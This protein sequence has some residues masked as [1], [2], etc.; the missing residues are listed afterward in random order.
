MNL[1]I[2]LRS[3]TRT[4]VIPGILIDLI[5]LLHKVKVHYVFKNNTEHSP[6]TVN[7]QLPTEFLGLF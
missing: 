4:S 2:C 1:E 6:G 7:L 3:L 5:N